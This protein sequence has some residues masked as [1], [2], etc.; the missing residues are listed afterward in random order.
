M[1]VLLSYLTI[2]IT[3]AYV[4]MSLAFSADAAPAGG[5]VVANTPTPSSTPTDTPTPTNTPTDT[6]TPTNTPTSTD[7][8]TPTN[9]LTPTPSIGASASGYWKNHLANA[10]S[11]GPFFDATCADVRRGDGGCSSNG[12][13]AKQYLPK[14]L[15]NYSVSN[16][17]TAA[18]VF[19]GAKC[20]ST[21][22]QDA[23]GCLTG[24]LLATKLS[25]ANGSLACPSILQA[26]ADSDAF[27][28]G[29]TVNG[30]PGINYTG[31]SGKYILTAAQRNLALSLK[32]KLF[33][34]NEN[35]SCS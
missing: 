22:D 1:R 31:P 8:P 24:Q 33:R 7:T 9:T 18:Q 2:A 20:S 25:L 19:G 30:V 15:G 10:S 4:T 12:P 21:K 11:S 3:V 16:I 5:T 14:S 6:P 35:V 26:V 27:L 17:T 23:I 13:W 29:Q 28:K 32:D 34:Y